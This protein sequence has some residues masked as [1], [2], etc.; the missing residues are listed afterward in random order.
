MTTNALETVSSP[1]FEVYPNPSNGL[2]TITSPTDNATIS[3]T[4]LLGQ[5]IL[6]THVRQKSTNVVLNENGV[7][8]VHLITTQSTT[9]QKIIVSK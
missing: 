7:Y 2:F 8:I 1:L 9:T 5:E 4:N 3:I 6:K